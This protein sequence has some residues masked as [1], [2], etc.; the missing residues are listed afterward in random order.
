MFQIR[1]PSKGSIC[2][3][4]VSSTSHVRDLVLRRKKD[5]Y[6]FPI[7]SHSLCFKQ[8]IIEASQFNDLNNA[9][10]TKPAMIPQDF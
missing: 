10:L 1:D 8:V 6:A 9:M 5:Y 7:V 4:N 2:I 3:S